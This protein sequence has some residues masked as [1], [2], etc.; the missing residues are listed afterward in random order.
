[1][2]PTVSFEIKG[3]LFATIIIH[4]DTHGISLK[5]KRKLTKKS[6]CVCVCVF[7]PVCVCV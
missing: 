1:M 5:R 2:L 7:V 4:T 3:H 6:V